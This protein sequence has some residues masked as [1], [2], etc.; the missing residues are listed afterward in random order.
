VG[1]PRRLRS[2]RATDADEQPSDAWEATEAIP[3][4]TVRSAAP[5]FLPSPDLRLADLVHEV[6]RGSASA[7]ERLYDAVADQVYGVALRVLR[8]PELAEDA[9]QEALLEVWTTAPRFETARGSARGWI[10]TIAHRRAVDRVRREESHASRARAAHAAAFTSARADDGP[11]RVVDALQ[12]EW[13]A[14]RVR[15]ALA[16][17][18][19]L[20]REALSLAYWKGLTHSEVA[21]E[22]GIPLGTAKARLRDGLLRMRDLLD[23]V[24]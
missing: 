21:S 18:S 23:V 12:A 9:A 2:V 5:A 8:D 22:L 19:E 4:A 24:R 6:A 10:L 20:Q 1:S 14:T 11:A 13:E 17:L 16:R 3:P 15:R 7:F